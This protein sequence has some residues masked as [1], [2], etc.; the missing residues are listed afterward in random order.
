MSIEKVGNVL[1]RFESRIDK[2]LE[3]KVR[4][5]NHYLDEANLRIDQQQLID[6]GAIKKAGALRKAEKW[7]NDNKE[8]VLEQI[9]CQFPTFWKVI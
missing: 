8:F 3:V 6:A 1:V 9:N 7:M 4:I 2:K 5:N